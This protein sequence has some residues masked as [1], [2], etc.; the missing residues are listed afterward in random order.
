MKK[1]ILSL[2]L[3]SALTVPTISHAAE[4]SFVQKH[5]KNITTSVEQKQ[6]TTPQTS[7]QFSATKAS[8][9]VKNGWNY[10]NGYWYYIKNGQ[11]QY[12][13][14]YDGGKWYYLHESSG[15]MYSDGWYTIGG[16]DYY[17]DSN[18]FMKVGWVH[19]GT[20]WAYTNASGAAHSGWLYDAGKWYYIPA[21]KYMYANTPAL[22]NGSY[23]YFGYNG[24]MMTGWVYTSNSWAY[25]KAN[26]AQHVGWLYDA[27]KWYYFYQGYTMVTNGW[28]TIDG[29]SYYFDAN[30]VYQYSR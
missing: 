25:F 21:G 7:T 18:G 17:F 27:G 16:Q 19:D 9:Q 24:A 26:G 30:G 12:G 2:L 10:Y 22:I 3:V 8:Q 4:T 15:A 20:G 28:A 29:V 13:W 6:I 5:S 14:L 1:K 11:L 23:Y